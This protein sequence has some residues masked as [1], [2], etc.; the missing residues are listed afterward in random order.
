MGTYTVPVHVANT[1]EVDGAGLC[2]SISLLRYPAVSRMGP[3][4]Q[5]GG[6]GV[7]TRVQLS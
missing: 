6:G 2:C 1:A 7:W 5:H 3:W 4:V